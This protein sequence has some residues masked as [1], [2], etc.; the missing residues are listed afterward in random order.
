MRLGT[1]LLILLMVAA[2]PTLVL[3]AGASLRGLGWLIAAGAAV[4]LLIDLTDRVT[5]WLE[6][7]RWGR[8]RR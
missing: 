7:R 5:E 2:V 6:D 4:V 3:E 8:R 1:W